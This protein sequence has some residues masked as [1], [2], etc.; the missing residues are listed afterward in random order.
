MRQT[1]RRHWCLNSVAA[2]A[3][4]LAPRRAV[5]LTGSSDLPYHH[6]DKSTPELTRILEPD[7]RVEV[8]DKTT[9]ITA[10]ALAGA[11]VIVVNYNG[12]RWGSTAE[13]ATEEAVRAGTGIVSLHMASYGFSDLEQAPGKG[14]I[15]P[16]K[17]ELDWPAWHEMVGAW[18]TPEGLT[19]A[20]S[21]R[22]K[23]R[24]DVAAP[25]HSITGDMGPWFELTDELYNGIAVMPRSQVL[26]VAFDDPKQRN[27]TGLYQPMAWC[28][29]FGKGRTF[30]TTLGHDLEAMSSSG[31]R[32]LFNRGARW[33]AGAL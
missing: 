19:R 12:P 17:P 6:W 9:A 22:R 14:W 3:A 18:W 16:N 15:K 25:A 24:V 10:R 7:L 26:A 29:V 31:F 2:G 4:M 13:G 1:T 28:G 32:Q 11:S 20:H 33:A 21:V 27:A 23:I 8:I 5:I 30:H